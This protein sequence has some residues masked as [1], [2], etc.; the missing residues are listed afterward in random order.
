MSGVRPRYVVLDRDGTLV[1]HV[2]YLKSPAGVQLLPTVRDGLSALQRAG[3]VLF[4][5]TNQSGAGRGFFTMRD[6]HACNAEM[7]SQIGLGED[8]FEQICIAPET[9]DDDPVYRKPSG[10][11]GREIMHTYRAGPEQ[12]CYIGDS[13]SDLLTA[14]HLGC[15]GVGVNTGLED[16]SAAVRADDTLRDCPVFATFSE[17][18]SFVL[19]ATH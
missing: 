19:G 16:L 2:L 14:K 5:H 3:C 8:L 7:I 15:M 11:F 4:L 6:A 10:R 9:P 1:R 17:A 13:P 12:V 18:A